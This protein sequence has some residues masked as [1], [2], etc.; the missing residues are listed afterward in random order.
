MSNESLH[1]KRG[2]DR[3]SKAWL[4]GVT[5]LSGGACSAFFGNALPVILE[6]SGV[7][8][9]NIGWYSIAAT[10]P[11]CLSFLYAPITDFGFRWKTWY[12]LLTMLT[13]AAVIAAL[14]VRVPA[15]LTLFLIL[16]LIGRIASSL[17]IGCVSALASTTL[18]ENERDRGAGWMVAGV[19]VGGTLGSFLLVDLFYGH[20]LRMIAWVYAAVLLVP[21][22]S[23]ILVHE[24]VRPR[25]APRETLRSFVEEFRDLARQEETWAGILVCILPTGTW[26]VTFFLPALGA[27]YRA[28][29]SAI[30]T[31]NG[32]MSWVL[33]AAGGFLGGLA[34]ARFNRY[35]VYLFASLCAAVNQLFLALAPTQPVFYVGF[36]LVL[37]FIQGISMTAAD[38]VI[39]SVIKDT[40]R[41]TC[42]QVNLLLSANYF[43]V[44]YV[45]FVDT[46]MSNWF[47]VRGLVVADAL[48]IFCG[49]VILLLVTRRLSSSAATQ[50][51]PS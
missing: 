33:C 51:S 40:R 21:A 43:S 36:S 3:F 32:A 6:R 18:G 23:M 10:L 47:G 42:L 28:P 35:R 22:A 14:L 48:L 41:S 30:A 20:S 19:T 8:I 2:V 45:T 16:I 46:K 5:A 31:A 26:A 27:Y 44:L 17:T 9:E 25:Q 12:I 1:P 38:S 11:L 13:T 34:C 39:F 4:F 24:P 7:Q 49:V 50:K 15:E 37:F 29:A